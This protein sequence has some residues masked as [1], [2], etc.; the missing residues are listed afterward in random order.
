MEQIILFIKSRFER[1]HY[2]NLRSALIDIFRSISLRAL[3]L[4]S[5][6]IF[7]FLLN[8][9]H[10]ASIITTNTVSEVI[11]LM[12]PG[13]RSSIIVDPEKCIE[14]TNLTSKSI[15]WSMCSLFPQ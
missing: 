14:T 10:D 8:G 9:P 4:L 3:R 1:G 2:H 15:L 5:E 12:P 7:S 13:D 11:A 6:A